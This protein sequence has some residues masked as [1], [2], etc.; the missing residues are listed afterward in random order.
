MV[1][2]DYLSHKI[3][4]AEIADSID[5]KRKATQL[6]GHLV[7]KVMSKLKST[8]LRIV[9]VVTDASSTFIKFFGKI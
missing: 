2:M 7:E 3:L 5:V 9:E 6:E 8:G 1:F 4:H